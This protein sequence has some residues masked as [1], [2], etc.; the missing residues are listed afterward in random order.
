MIEELKLLLKAIEGMAGAGVEVMYLYMGYLYFKALLT[1][2]VVSS[3]LLLVYRLIR[4]GADNI[5]LYESRAAVMEQ[6]RD[7][8]GVGTPGV[9]TG[10]EL[11]EMVQWAETHSRGDE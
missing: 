6:L 11:K 10:S 5:A 7:T 2:L 1:A 3:G 8:M 4:R 9:V